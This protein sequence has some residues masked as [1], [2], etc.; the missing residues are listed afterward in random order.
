MLTSPP[1]KANKK[2]EIKWK[3]DNGWRRVSVEDE[4]KEIKKVRR[5]M[6]VMDTS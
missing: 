5:L 3:L 1:A 4:L 6:F 2:A